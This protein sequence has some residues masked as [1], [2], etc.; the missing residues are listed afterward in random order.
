MAIAVGLGMTIE[1]AADAVGLTRH[2]YY[3]HQKQDPEL[4]DKWISYGSTIGDKTVGLRIAKINA[5]EKAEDRIKTLFGRAFAITEKV[6]EKAEALGDNITIDAAM[7]IHQK[8]TVWAAR[9]TAQEAAK[10]V[11]VSG[12]VLHGH[13][14]LQDDTVS[15]LGSLMQH[16]G[17]IPSIAGAVEI[18]AEVTDG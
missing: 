10:V 5:S 3:A 14:M 17:T 11:K 16:M 7:E 15:A 1:E 12:G 13:V 2:T 4:F 9:F 8:I 6:I 18:N